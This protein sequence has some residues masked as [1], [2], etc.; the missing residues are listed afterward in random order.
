MVINENR[1]RFHKRRITEQLAEPT[2]EVQLSGENRYEDRHM[3]L[4]ALA[5]LGSRQLGREGGW[6]FP[7]Q[8]P[9]ER[10]DVPLAQ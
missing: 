10:S 6:N 3:L 5:A 1:R 8:R 4:T 9:P 7:R 2:P